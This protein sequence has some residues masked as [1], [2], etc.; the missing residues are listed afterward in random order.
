MDCIHAVMGWAAQDHLSEVIYNIC[1]IIS[2]LS[3]GSIEVGSY[4]VQGP[5]LIQV[6]W[7]SKQQK[8]FNQN[9]HEVEIRLYSPSGKKKKKQKQLCS[10]KSIPEISQNTKLR[11]CSSMGQQRSKTPQAESGRR[12][13]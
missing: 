1:A 9:G 6:T 3:D 11:L 5:A 13:L 10:D 8:L 2:F 4:F 7:E 12:G